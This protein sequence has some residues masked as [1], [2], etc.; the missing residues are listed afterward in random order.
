MG[1]ETYLVD[2][3]TILK[4]HSSP[5][6]LLEPK[7]VHDKPRV[8]REA[9]QVHS[10]HVSQSCCTCERQSGKGLTK[11]VAWT[12]KPQKGL[13]MNVRIVQSS[14]GVRTHCSRRPRSRVLS[15]SHRSTEL[16][17]HRA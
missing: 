11:E 4:L 1:L 6:S 5:E 14:G 12:G 16:D 2:K 7:R 3:D 8:V 15:S 13:L 9:E 10:V 17:A